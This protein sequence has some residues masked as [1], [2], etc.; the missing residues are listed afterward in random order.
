MDA[1][2]RTINHTEE[3]EAGV[4]DCLD[5]WGHATTAERQVQLYKAQVAGKPVGVSNCEGGHT[6]CRECG[7]G[8]CSEG[9]VLITLYCCMATLTG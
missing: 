8:E 9:V 4:A 5:Q 2:R 1:C 3:E 7:E 6:E